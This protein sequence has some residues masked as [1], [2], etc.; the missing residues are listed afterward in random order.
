MIGVFF[1]ALSAAMFLAIVAAS[2]SDSVDFF[3][4]A[5]RGGLV[6]LK[7]HKHCD[8]LCVEVVSAGSRVGTD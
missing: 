5:S 3:V 2:S 6:K 1:L 7:N 8:S 4:G